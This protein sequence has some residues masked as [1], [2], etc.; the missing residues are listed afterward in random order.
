MTLMVFSLT[1]M[2]LNIVNADEQTTPEVTKIEIRENYDNSVPPESI[3]AV[4]TITGSNLQ[5]VDVIIQDQSGLDNALG[6]DIGTRRTNT[7]NRLQFW[8]DGNDLDEADLSKGFIINGETIKFEEIPGRITGVDNRIIKYEEDEARVVLKGSGLDRGDIRIRDMSDFEVEEGRKDEKASIKISEDKFGF[9][10]IILSVESDGEE[11]PS[12]VYERR[13]ANQFRLIQDWQVDDL[14]MTPSSGVRD[15]TIVTFTGEGLERSSVFFLRDIEGRYEL[16]HMATPHDW[17]DERKRLQVVVPDLSSGQYNVVLTNY[18]KDVDPNE[19]LRDRITRQL[20]VQQPFVVIEAEDAAEIINISPDN[21]PNE[22]QN[23]ITIEG[24]NFEEYHNIDSLTIEKDLYLDEECPVGRGDKFDRENIKVTDD[25]ELLKINYGEGSYRISEEDTIKGEVYREITAYVG[26]KAMFIDKDNLFF[27]SNRDVLNLTLPTVSSD[28]IGYQDVRLH[29]ETIIVDK[30]NDREVSFTE[31]VVVEDGFYFTESSIIP[32]I[33]EVVPDRI[34]VVSE[35]VDGYETKND[36]VL[37]IEGEDFMVTRYRDDDAEKVLYPEVKLG[38]SITI[39]RENNVVMVND[40]II[41]EANLEV[42]NGDFLVNGHPGNEMGDRIFITLPEGISIKPEEVDEDVDI[43]VSNYKRRSNQ[44]AS[45]GTGYNFLRFYQ[46]ENDWDPTIDLVDPNVVSASEGREGIRI[47]GSRFWDDVAVFIGGELIEAER[48]NESLITFD[49]PPSRVGETVLTV[50]NLHPE[51]GGQVSYPFYYIATKDNPVITSIAP[52]EGT[53]GS[54]IVISGENFFAPDPSVSNLEDMLNINRIIGSKVL[55]NNKDV[56]EYNDGY[57]L[58]SYSNSEDAIISIDES[59][60]INLSDYYPSVFLR[61]DNEDESNIY[62]IVPHDEIS[63]RV[64]NYTSDYIIRAYENE[65][66]YELRTEQEDYFVEVSEEG[67]KIKDN[68]DDFELFFNMVTPYKAEGSEIIGHRAKV[69]DNDNKLLVT[70]PDLGTPGLYDVTVRNPDMLEDT[71]ED[72][73]RFNKG[74]TAVP[75][76]EKVAPKEGSVAGGYT[77]VIHGENFEDGGSPDTTTKV[78]ID[79]QPAEVINVNTS[80][81]EIEVTVPEYSGNLKDELEEQGIAIP[82]KDVPVAV[83]NPSTGASDLVED[84]FSYVIPS[85]EPNIERLNKYEG[86]AAGGEYIQITGTDFRYHEPFYTQNIPTDGSVPGRDYIDINHNNT[87]D[88]YSGKTIEELKEDETINFEEEVLPVLPKVYFGTQQAEIVDFG[89]NFLGVKTPLA[90]PGDVDVYVV[91]NDSG[92]SN[93]VRFTYDSLD[94]QINEIIPN[95]GNRIGK[96]NVDIHGQEFAESE[97]NKLTPDGEKTEQR[98]P[99][100]KFGDITNRYDEDSGIIVGGQVSNLVLEGNLTLNYNSNRDELRV[101]LEHGQGEYYNEFLYDDTKVFINLSL[102]EDSAGQNWPGNEMISVEIDRGAT[103][104]LIVERGFSPQANFENSSQLTVS[105]SSY[106]T[107]GTVPVTVVNPDGGEATD[108][109]T[110]MHPDSNPEIINITRDSR[111]PIRTEHEDEDIMLLNM[112]YEGSSV[113]S[114]FGQDFRENAIIQVGDLF[115]IEPDDISYR[116]PEQLT[117]TMPDVP[118]ARVGELFRVI[119][120]NDDG[121]IASSDETQPPIYLQ[122]TKGET[123]PEITSVTPQL[124]P[125]S[126]GTVIKIEGED[127]RGSMEGYEGEGPRVYFDEQPANQVNVIDY[128]NIEVVSPLNSPGTRTIRVE[129][130]D[131][132]ISSESEFEYISSPRINAV[133]DPRDPTETTRIRNISIEGGDEIKLKGTGF[134]EGARVIFAPETSLAEGNPGGNVIYR[135]TQEEDEFDGRTFSSNVI[136]YHQLDEGEEG[137]NVTFIDEETLTVE[138]P[139]GR[140]D[141]SGIIVINPDDGAS[142]TYEDITYDLP[143]MEIPQDVTAEIV[144]DSYNNTDRFIRINWTKVDE[145]AEY[146]IYVIVDDDGQQRYIGTTELSSYLYEDLKPRTEYQFVVKAIG[147]HGSSKASMESNI[148]ETGRNVGP[149]D[150][151][152]DITEHTEM[153]RVGNTANVT[154]GTR[155]YD[156]AET[157]IDLTRG[158]LA[159]ASEVVVSMPARVASDRRAEDI[160]IIGNDFSMSFNPVAFRVARVDENRNRDDAGVRFT[161]APFNGNANIPGGNDLST[162]YDLGADFYLGQNSSSIDYLARPI[163]FVV[164]YDQDK[165]SM[166]RLQ[167]VGMHRLESD[168]WEPIDWQSYL[169]NSVAESL[170]RLGSYTVIGSRR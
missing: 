107:V 1:I 44:L 84:A 59:G 118:E 139:P 15:R 90:T 77:V 94:P 103:N 7:E 51:E 154:I 101:S 42:F 133:V 147:D 156:R 85:S 57:Q 20:E 170:N 136:D 115:T 125:A 124:G 80:R 110:Y 106:Y 120:Q 113:V 52:D 116:L 64:T 65:D 157:V 14:I 117:F 50:H 45:N 130:P 4:L 32:T 86:N 47:E 102:L 111:E 153:Q 58:E 95:V 68:D 54:K 56:N 81:T 98:M 70:I 38:D 163:N 9:S 159:G 35:I 10:D 128:K 21:G 26:P 61:E 164:D 142:E 40:E 137:T 55:F 160:K 24:R 76:I 25:E 109:F 144:H 75:R 150:E 132:E 2:P 17:N 88:D 162:V 67:I 11:E 96:Q 158:D 93:K 48:V 71:W 36:I 27:S 169:G 127:F 39:K 155:D 30:D 89:E 126:G 152:G 129:N 19:D 28:Y 16:E 167:N 41:E 123:N 62:K 165:A 99:L 13:Y 146:E 66:G 112:N 114:I 60:N 34:Q 134:M 73:F 161:V 3:D 148:V 82:K 140:L 18:M 74:M 33:N 122:F 5:N 12:L 92:I 83:S 145:A 29:I 105:T 100:V 138:V 97:F 63:V 168:G 8:L 104:R 6:R 46:L 78:W 23:R 166:R 131:G 141:T 91:N 135:V 87:W 72:G 22:I 37:A 149:P 53:I 31:E 43:E 143:E 151:D 79:S 69:F 121:G 119:V 49:A 108:E